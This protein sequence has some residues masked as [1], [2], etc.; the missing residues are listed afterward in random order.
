[1]KPK[2]NKTITTK[3]GGNIVIPNKII[4]KEYPENTPAPAEEPMLYMLKL[5]KVPGVS[6]ININAYIHTN[7][8]TYQSTPYNNTKLYY[9]SGYLFKD[10]LD[11]EKLGINIVCQIYSIGIPNVCPLGI[12]FNNIV[13]TT[14]TGDSNDGII[15]AAA[16][17]NV[18]FISNKK[19][20]LIVLTHNFLDGVEY[21]TNFEL[22]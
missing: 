14:N 17:N 9:K 16:N 15:Y 12:T 7:T 4:S 1:M 19:E 11:R 13:K 5:T 20:Q 8:Y 22:D 21:E 6:P 2:I 18:Y 10:T 3:G